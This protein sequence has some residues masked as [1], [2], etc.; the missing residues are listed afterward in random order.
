MNSAEKQKKMLFTQSVS[1]KRDNDLN[2]KFEVNENYNQTIQEEMSTW[3]KRMTVA[4]M[5]Q[6][7]SISL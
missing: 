3:E 7:L 6:R 2:N 1:D 4:H 5:L